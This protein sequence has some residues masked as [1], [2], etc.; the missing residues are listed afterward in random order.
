[1][2]SKEEV[3]KI[4]DKKIFT[5]KEELFSHTSKLLQHQNT[6]PKTIEELNQIKK[7]CSS[8]GTEIALMNQLLNKVCEQQNKQED[9][10]DKLN[11]DG[12][13]Q[14]AETMEKLETISETKADKSSLDKLESFVS[15]VMWISITSLIGFL[16]SIVVLLVQELSKN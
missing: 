15:R 8:R 7:N 3:E 10:I 12:I 5:L 2:C 11:Q 14:H 4:I 1:M 9:K 16:V 13:I 6:S